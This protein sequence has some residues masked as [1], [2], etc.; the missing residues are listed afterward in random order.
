MASIASRPIHSGWQGIDHLLKVKMGAAPT[1]PQFGGAGAARTRM[2]KVQ[3]RL[4]TLPQLSAAEMTENK[5][6]FI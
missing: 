3:S 2:Q 5:P 6:S 4:W 1:W